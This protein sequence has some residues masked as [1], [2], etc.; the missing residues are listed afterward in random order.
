MINTLKI[1]FSKSIE[2]TM[3]SNEIKVMIIVK[4]KKNKKRFNGMIIY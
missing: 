4:Q 2:S 3:N 1:N